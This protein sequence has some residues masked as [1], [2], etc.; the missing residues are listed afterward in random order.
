[1]SKYTEADKSQWLDAKYH[2][3]ELAERAIVAYWME[4]RGSDNET[5]YHVD[6]MHKEFL[7]LA[8]ALGYSVIKR[9]GAA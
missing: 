9:G 7:Q 4:G 6:A 8:Q 5:E 1:M 3:K 2:A